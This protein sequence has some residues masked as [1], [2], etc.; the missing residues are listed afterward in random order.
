MHQWKRRFIVV[1]QTQLI[2]VQ[3]QWRRPWTRGIYLFWRGT[4]KEGVRWSLAGMNRD[5]EKPWR[6]PDDRH[7]WNKEAF[8]SQIVST[9][10]SDHCAHWKVGLPH[11]GFKKAGWVTARFL[12]S[13]LSLNI[14]SFSPANPTLCFF[15]VSSSLFFLPSTLALHHERL[16]LY[17][18]TLNDECWVTLSFS[19]S[20]PSFCLGMANICLLHLCVFFS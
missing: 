4:M 10:N 5:Y 17:T 15:F 12:N 8:I 2:L 20:H 11:R 9:G 19:P 6:G 13:D 1:L 16:G 14:S 3:V 18:T 7:S